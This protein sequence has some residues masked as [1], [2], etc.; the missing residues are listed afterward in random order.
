MKFPMSILHRYLLK[1]FLRNLFLACVS[2]IVLFLVFDFFDRIDNILPKNPNFE[3]VMSY[4]VFKIPQFFVLSLPV[5]FIVATLFTYGIL[6]KN[7]EIV[8]MR[9]AGLKLSWLAWPLIICGIIFSLI[10]LLCTETILPHS[11]RR[12]KEIY[13]IDIKRKDETG[14]YSQENIWWRSG[15]N[16]Y[17]VEAFDS[18]DSSLHQF[19]QYKLADDFKLRERVDSCLL[20]TSDAADE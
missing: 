6:S 10:N 5:S 4:F 9:A 19:S 11:I 15:N 13:N 2:L 16:F 17:S 7:S 12:V 1:Q 20:Y 8:A 3:T 14:T 18:R